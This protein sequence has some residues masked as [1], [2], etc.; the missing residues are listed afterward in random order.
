MA[1][2]RRS[3]EF[4]EVCS[5]AKMRVH[6]AYRTACALLPDADDRK[7]VRIARK[8][9]TLCD[10]RDRCFT[11]TEAGLREIVMQNWQCIDRECPSCFFWEPMSRQI[12]AYFAEED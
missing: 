7:R 3:R 8:I 2:K 1:Y 9:L 10:G 4:E 6:V 5:L 11:I 12:N